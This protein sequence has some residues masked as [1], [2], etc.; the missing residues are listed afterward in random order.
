MVGLT[1]CFFKISKLFSDT[2]VLTIC[3]FREYNFQAILTASS[4]IYGF[5]V[6]APGSIWMVLRQYDAN[7]RFITILCLY[8]YSLF[9]FLPAVVSVFYCHRYE[10]SLSRNSWLLN[11]QL[12]CLIPSAYLDDMALFAAGALSSLFLLRNLGPF[13]MTHAKKQAA[14]L[15][16]SIG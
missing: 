3:F 6:I 16:G 4:L 12:V 9:V 10:L 5:A 15:L 7:L 11:V 1:L 2:Y 8:G 14:V 13:I